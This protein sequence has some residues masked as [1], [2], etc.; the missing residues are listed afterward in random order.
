VSHGC[1]HGGDLVDHGDA[2]FCLFPQ[3][4]PYVICGED[5]FLS[6]NGDQSAA[7]SEMD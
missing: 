2:D 1:W 5:E 3:C 4:S 7:A 6:V